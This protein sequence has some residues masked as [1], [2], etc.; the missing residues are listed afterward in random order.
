MSPH[1]E[2]GLL[3]YLLRNLSNHDEPGLLLY[4]KASYKRVSCGNKRVPQD[5]SGI[6]R[7]SVC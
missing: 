2:P 4:V 7:I 3:L 5:D 1:R 6:I